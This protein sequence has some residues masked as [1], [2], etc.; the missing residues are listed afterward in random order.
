MPQS[1]FVM[2]VAV[3]ITVPWDL[4]SYILVWIYRR[5][6]EM[7]FLHLQTR[8]SQYFPFPW[9]VETHEF[10]IDDGTLFTS[11]YGGVSRNSRTDV[12]A[13]YTTPNKRLWKLPTSTQ[14]RATW[15]TGSLDMVVL[16]STGA[17][18]Y[19]NCCIDG[20]TT[21]EYFGCTLVHR[22]TQILKPLF[23]NFSWWPSESYVLW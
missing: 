17:S 9:K 21:P 11:L 1:K 18:R 10:L 22:H 16:P 4:T 14:L 13:K 20:G 3:K 23:E 15:H 2:V 6:E 19:H 12:I 5:F 7:F 8:C